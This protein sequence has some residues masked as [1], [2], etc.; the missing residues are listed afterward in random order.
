[1]G[2]QV[3]LTDSEMLR[4]SI[5]FCQNNVTITIPLTPSNLVKYPPLPA[6]KNLET[7]LKDPSNN[8]SQL[9][10]N[11]KLNFYKKPENINYKVIPN[12]DFYR[13]QVIS[14]YFQNS[15]QYEFI[16]IVTKKKNYK[17]KNG[18][19]NHVLEEAEYNIR[20]NIYQ[21]VDSRKNANANSFANTTVT[22]INEDFEN[23]ISFPG[24][25]SDILFVF[26]KK[27]QFLNTNN[28]LAAEME[29]AE[30]KHKLNNLEKSGFD[31]QEIQEFVSKNGTN[32]LDLPQQKYPIT[33]ILDNISAMTHHELTRHL[34][35][36]ANI[37]QVLIPNLDEKAKNMLKY[38]SPEL[39]ANKNVKIL[40]ENLSWDN[41]I[42]DVK[43]TNDS[44]VVFLDT[45]CE[46]DEEQNI[47]VNVFD[48]LDIIQDPE[49]P[50]NS[51]L[52][53]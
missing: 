26:K 5:K 48:Y 8:I 43:K 36:S 29:L 6:L 33:L 13:D 38:K 52:A 50:I 24:D 14:A 25:K 34:E 46:S 11:A 28:L 7:K 21:I 41:V 30:I 18:N 10:L 37:L 19:L 23:S 12:N 9:E 16:E 20:E 49:N 4:R 1:M 44:N 40:A 45:S 3:E 31:D 17:S 51:N 39:I 2:S 32:E 27:E 15:E 42:E 53:R 35:N 22:T 47:S